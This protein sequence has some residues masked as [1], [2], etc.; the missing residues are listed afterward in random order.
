MPIR[1]PIP[2]KADLKNFFL[3]FGSRLPSA[4]QT[5]ALELK[6]WV[7]GV[8]NA[9]A[10]ILGPCMIWVTKKT[11]PSRQQRGFDSAH[12]FFLLTVK[13]FCP[14]LDNFFD[15]PPFGH[16]SSLYRYY[17]ITEASPPPLYSAAKLKRL[18]V[19]S[20]RELSPSAAAQK[21]ENNINESR[22][23]NGG[24]WLTTH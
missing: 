1:A 21:K 18:T 5:W 11:F 4:Y 20:G 17:D 19:C 7:T 13:Q 15:L 24:G 9:K 12:L 3:P 10:R 22:G 6:I 2:E 14:P 23:G 8:F 16:A